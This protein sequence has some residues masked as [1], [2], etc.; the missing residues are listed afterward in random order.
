MS[1][2]KRKRQAKLI[3]QLKLSTQSE[4]FSL[5]LMFATGD[6]RY[7]SQFV[8]DG[9]VVFVGV[10]FLYSAIQCGQVDVRPPADILFWG[11]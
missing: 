2:N 7:G 6:E 11:L 10:V 4:E 8:H 1:Y 3:S 9:S 5:P